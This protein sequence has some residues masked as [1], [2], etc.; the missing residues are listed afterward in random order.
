MFKSIFTKYFSLFSIVLV[1]AVVLLGSSQ[2]LFSYRYWSAE[3][4]AALSENAAQV[5]AIA[6]AGVQV[7]ISGQYQLSRSVEPYLSALTG[8]TDSNALIV[9][10]DGTILL[11]ATSSEVKPTNTT[12]P[13]SLLTALRG[14]TQK[15]QTIAFPPAIMREV[16]EDSQYT[17]ACPIVADRVIGYALVSTSAQALS[18]FMW[19]NLK[20]FFLSALMVIL[21]TFLVSY[22][23]TDRLV[24][25]LRQM[26]A[27][28][29]GFATGDFSAR[30]PVRG[31]DEIAELAVSLNAMAVSL[32]SEEEMRR[33]FVANVSHELKTPMT[34]IAGFID[35]ILDGT[36]PEN[37][38]DH[39]LKVVSDEVKRLSRLVKSMLDLS[40]ID[41]GQLKLNP[42]SF[43]LTET[44][45]NALFSFEQRI[46]ERDITIEGLEDCPRMPVCGDYDLLGQ[47]VYNLLDNATKFTDPGGTIRITL[48]H[49]DRRIYC[50]VWNTGMGI[51]AHELP[52]IFERFY[53]TDKSRGLDKNGVG[54]GLYI[55]QNVIHLHNGEITVRS[56]EGQYC[57]FEFW[58]PEDP[59]AA[60]AEEIV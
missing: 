58:L 35:G 40:R 47:V 42:V 19:N 9:S 20:I 11:S 44:V 52:R 32:S 46:V 17:V 34:T 28:V 21:L 26:A 29:R 5:A 49:A 3:K 2:T 22:V 4:E 48:R 7:D 27:A 6:A 37:R 53:K 14:L 41:A 55:V 33:S 56:A 25:P 38:R 15:G 13:S 54:L 60:Y 51:P 24:R 45:G 12:I 8:L 59:N 31:K 16:Y 10:S 57:A 39:Y 36:I 1:S 18:D 43:D 23:T 30:I 50:T